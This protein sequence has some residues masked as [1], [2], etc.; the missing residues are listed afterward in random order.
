MSDEKEK[1]PSWDTPESE[2]TNRIFTA[3]NVVSFIRL[4]M[5]PVYLVLL[6]DGHDILATFIFALAASTDFIDGQLA[7]RTHTVSRLGR[8]L[9]PAVDRALMVFGVVGLLLVG[10]LVRVCRPHFVHLHDN[11]VCASWH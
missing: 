4:C 6:L 7:R 2:V 1:R 3:A 9:D 11:G 5:V 8:L 10:H